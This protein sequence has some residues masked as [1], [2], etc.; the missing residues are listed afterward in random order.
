MTQDNPIP[1][2]QLNFTTNQPVKDSSGIAVAGTLSLEWGTL[3]KH[4]GNDTYRQ[5]AEKSTKAIINAPAPLPGLPGQGIDVTGTPTNGY[6]VSPAPECQV[7]SM[8]LIVLNRHGEE[9]LTAISSTSLSMPVLRTAM[10]LYMPPH[11]K[12]P[13]THPSRRCSR[14]VVLWHNKQLSF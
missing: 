7:D 5:L 3:A 6:V 2:N 9:A 12:L 11:G 1:Y 4:T 10:T 8:S 14:L 13:S